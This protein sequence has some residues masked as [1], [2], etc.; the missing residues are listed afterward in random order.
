V[1]IQDS[2]K[3]TPASS[4]VVVWEQLIFSKTLTLYASVFRIITSSPTT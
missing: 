1:S 3:D 4:E 2:V